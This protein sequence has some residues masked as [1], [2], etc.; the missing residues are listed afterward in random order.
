L[1]LVSALCA[2]NGTLLAA[3]IDQHL[4]WTGQGWPAAKHI[5]PTLSV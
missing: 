3:S 2:E 5:F 1:T 4:I